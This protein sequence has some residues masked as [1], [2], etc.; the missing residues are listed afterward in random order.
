MMIPG[1]IYLYISLC[2]TL[3]EVVSYFGQKASRLERTYRQGAR[4]AHNL[5]AG[6]EK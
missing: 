4:L 3:D 2:T 5:Y 6:L 1:K